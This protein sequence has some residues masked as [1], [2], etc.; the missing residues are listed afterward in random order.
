VIKMLL[1]QIVSKVQSIVED[2]TYWNKS[3]ITTM[4][5][6]FKD[7]ISSHFG[8]MANG[9]LLM[10][11][12]IA[13]RS[14]SLPLDFVALNY[15]TWGN[16]NQLTPSNRVNSPRDAA[17]YLSYTDV[18]A[19]P[20]NYFLW[21]KED[22]IE[23]WVVPTFNSV[24]E[25]ELFFWRRVP[26]VVNDNDEPMIPRDLHDK[27]VEYCRRQSWMEDELHNF[28]PERLDAWVFNELMQMQISKNVQLAGS[29][30]IGIG[31]W[32]DRMPRQN[33]DSVGFPIRIN[34][35]DGVTW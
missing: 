31:N 19:T 32:T 27:F 6:Q 8:L 1:H 21:S 5:N 9:Y 25:V 30:S 23:L 33:E 12:V 10:E 13:Q 4:V 18:P 16:G 26:D 24:V 22:H 14:Y 35:N 20:T 17:S 15:M 34:S 7:L 3:R 28:T 11:S 29:D 2:P